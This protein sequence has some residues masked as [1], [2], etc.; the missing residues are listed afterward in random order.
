M[1]NTPR[2]VVTEAKNH[3]R[4]YFSVEGGRQTRMT[5]VTVQYNRRLLA[6]TTDF[7]LEKPLLIALNQIDKIKPTREWNPPYEWEAP[8]RDDDCRKSPQH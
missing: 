8:P 2:Q 5:K 3:P 7:S 6:K 4:C 1:N